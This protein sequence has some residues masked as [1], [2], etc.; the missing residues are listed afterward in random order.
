MNKPVAHPHAPGSRKARREANAKAREQARNVE[1][2]RVIALR[3]SM[4]REYVVAVRFARGAHEV[5]VFGAGAIPAGEKIF[6]AWQE[7]RVSI[8]ERG[9]LPGMRYVVAERL[10]EALDGSL[11]RARAT[12]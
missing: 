5:A 1:Q 3:A 8:R 12:G 6:P 2:A 11:L 9:S 4:G 7:A 10:A